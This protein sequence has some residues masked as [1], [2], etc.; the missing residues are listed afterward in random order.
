PVRGAGEPRLRSSVN[1]TL[2]DVK[3]AKSAG[4]AAHEAREPFA[5]E[6]FA[7]IVRT[8]VRDLRDVIVAGQVEVVGEPSGVR[9]ARVEQGF[10]LR[11]ERARLELGIRKEQ[12]SRAG[13]KAGER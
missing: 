8:E 11:V 12:R 2:C 13:G 3:K 9:V 1:H 6:R 10:G 7:G 5:H 4:H